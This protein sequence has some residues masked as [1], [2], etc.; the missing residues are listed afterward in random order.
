MARRLKKVGVVAVAGLV[1]FLTAAQ[2]VRPERTNPPI[3]KARALHAQPGISSELVQ[4]LNRSCGDCHSNATDW[5]RYTTVA[6][7]SWVVTSAV[8]GGR[9]VMNISDWDSYP[10]AVR[11][12]LLF[13]SCES[14]TK[15]S[16]PGSIYTR[17]RPE[18]ALSARDIQII[19]AAAK[20]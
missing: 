2:F 7:L 10:P 16:M 12:T 15:G 14:A 17:L 1:V 8:N 11:Y 20:P 6:P 18:A 13:K 19:C 4:V 5:S 9:K 3:D